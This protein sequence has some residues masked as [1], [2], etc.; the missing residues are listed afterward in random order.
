MEFWSASEDDPFF[1]MEF[2][3]KAE[4]TSAQ[5]GAVPAA[6]K[7]RKKRVTISHEAAREMRTWLFEHRH[8]PR[9]TNL[10][11]S[12]FMQKYCLTRREVRTAFNNRR[13]RVLP[14][15]GAFGMWAAFG[16]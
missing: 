10:Q 15:F 4:P 2:D 12:Y 9:L 6:K 7:P 3:E 16:R 14:R 13:Q 1:Q 11:E 8:Y 5:T